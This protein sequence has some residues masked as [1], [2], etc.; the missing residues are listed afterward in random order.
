V[1][2]NQAQ[3]RIEVVGRVQSLM[4]HLGSR[5]ASGRNDSA[6]K[7]T[8]KLLARLDNFVLIDHEYL[9][10]MAGPARPC[11]PSGRTRADERLSPN[12][13]CYAQSIR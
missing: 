12:K 2:D 6:L 3:D 11:G 4:T 10:N 9:E 1:P 5:M 7:W 13:L 8:K